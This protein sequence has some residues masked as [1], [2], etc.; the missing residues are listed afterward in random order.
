MCCSSFSPDLRPHHGVSP[1]DGLVGSGASCLALQLPPGS[2]GSSAWAK[3]SSLDPKL[4]EDAN[5]PIDL[6]YCVLFPFGW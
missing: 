3:R 5:F 4:P 2:G 6:G 1:A